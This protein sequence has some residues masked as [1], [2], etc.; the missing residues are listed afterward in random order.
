M[1]STYNVTYILK[2][3]AKILMPVKSSVATAQGTTTTL[4]DT[5]RTEADD[6]YHRDGVGGGTIWFD[7][8]TAGNVGLARAISDYVQSTGTFTWV[9][10]VT[11]TEV[12]D[13]YTV[14][15][16]DFGLDILL[17]AL[18]AAVQTL[19]EVPQQYT[20]AALVTVVDQMT[21]TL[22]ADVYNVKR[23]EIANST[24]SPYLWQIQKHWRE[25][26]GEI[27]FPDGAQSK[28]A[29]YL[30]RLTYQSTPSI[31]TQTST[32]SKNYHID[33]LRWLG[34]LEALREKRNDPMYTTL[35]NE[36]LQREPA[37]KS[38]HRKQIQ[39]WDVKDDTDTFW[40]IY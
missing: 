13:G 36:A 16:V 22:P 35:L 20:N 18:N 38:L 29:D 6:F 40:S 8:G 34:A 1:A 37:M 21:Y 12:A 17:N 15:P 3:M 27:E 11:Q 19:G 5:T 32:L 24:T 14:S 25:I 39:A 10:A 26:G 31:L 33:V 9:T 23:V 30:I 4:I 28:V 7:S 2:E